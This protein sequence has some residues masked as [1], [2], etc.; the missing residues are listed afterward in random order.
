MAKIPHSPEEILEEFVSDVKVVFTE[1]LLS[2]ILYGS[3]AKGEYVRKKSDINFLIILTENGIL[4]LAKC[5]GLVKK[6]DK[7]NV[8]VPL[9]MSKEY[10]QS[11]LDSFPIE[12]LSMQQHHKLVYGEDVLKDLHISKEHLRLEFEEQIKGKLLHLRKEFLATAGNKRLLVRLISVTVP[13]FASLFTALLTLKDIEPPK[14]KDAILY[15]A[16]EALGLDREVFRQVIAVR[17]NGLKLSEN[18]LV[19]LMEKYIAEIRKLAF[20]VDKW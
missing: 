12:F 8:A 3:G 5:F 17:G 9:F 4:N 14:E 18:E 1:D 2:V 11:S 20:T 10:L 16:V 15:K 6:W 19:T 7:R 13:T